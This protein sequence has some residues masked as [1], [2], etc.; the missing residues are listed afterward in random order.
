MKVVA[1]R[2]KRG[3][4]NSCLINSQLSIRK[5]KSGSP[6][7]AGWV[8]LYHCSREAVFC[9]Y[10]L[11][12]LTSL[13]CSRIRTLL[14]TLFIFIPYLSS[15]LIYPSDFYVTLLINPTLDLGKFTTGDQ[16]HRLLIL[17]QYK[18]WSPTCCH[19]TIFAGTATLYKRGVSVGS[20]SLRR[21]KV[22][23][24]KSDPRY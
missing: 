4:D 24:K 14:H 5:G 11:G 18:K 2:R 10:W 3:N 6:R 12:E 21:N 17:H 8:G 9:H 23:L 16:L 7:Q 1:K 20:M 22:S 19:N 13:L 15:Y